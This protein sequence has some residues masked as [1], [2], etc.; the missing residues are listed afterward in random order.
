[1]TRVSA[2][3]LY[4]LELAPV[5]TVMWH[6]HRQ[7]WTAYTLWCTANR[8]QALPAQ[9][10]T[11]LAYLQHLSRRYANP[12]HM[13]VWYAALTRATANRYPHVPLGMPRAA[14]HA[15]DYHTTRYLDDGWRPPRLP[16]VL[17][18]DIRAAVDTCDDTPGGIRDASLLLTAFLGYLRPGHLAGYR[19]TDLTPTASGIRLRRRT[20]SITLEPNP[21]QPRY[22]PVTQMQAWTGELAAHGH[23]TGALYRPVNGHGHPTTTSTGPDYRMSDS[24]IHTII[25][26]AGHRAGIK[27]TT[28]SV[29]RAYLSWLRTAANDPLALTWM[30]TAAQ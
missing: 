21:A 3:C 10:P 26:R 18:D 20:M 5:P 11:V 29:R 17:P 16:P 1:M 7:E 25:G 2:T 14:S 24:A 9:E 30:L 6:S 8:H 19:L 27:L 23:T 13:W 22:C 28:L 4:P 15:I 12:S